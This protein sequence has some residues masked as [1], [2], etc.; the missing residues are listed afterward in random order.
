MGKDGILRTKIKFDSLSDDNRL[1]AGPGPDQ[2]VNSI[3][4][5]CGY[6]FPKTD[7]LADVLGI[8]HLVAD[9]TL[10]TAQVP[11]LVQRYKR[12]FILKLLPTAAAVCTEDNGM[13]G[14][15]LICDEKLY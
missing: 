2:E 11:V 4:K 15:L 10:E 5:K 8:E 13:K 9:F 6:V 7:L 3:M 14:D 12:L 1:N